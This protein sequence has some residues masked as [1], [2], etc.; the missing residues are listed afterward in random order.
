MKKVTIVWIVLL[1]VIM[2]S[3]NDDNDSNTNCIKET[4][5]AND[6]A[7]AK[8]IEYLS[9]QSSE[10]CAAYKNA[11]QDLI[12]KLN[13]CPNFPARET[14]KTASETRLTTLNCN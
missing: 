4:T 3:C 7:T 11:L 12:A 2:I 1:S 6:L 13:D 14:L 9:N 5:R 10:N 8:S